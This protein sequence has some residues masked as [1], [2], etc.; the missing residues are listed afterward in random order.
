MNLLA[1]MAKWAATPS[2]DFWR[3]RATKVSSTFQSKWN[4]SDESLRLGRFGRTRDGCSV[5]CPQ[6]TIR[7]CPLRTAD[8]TARK[9]LSRS[10]NSHDLTCV[11]PVFGATNESSAYRILE[12]IIPLGSVALVAW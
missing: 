9:L 7:H 8:S 4:S 6:R 2:G 1:I 3:R 10:I 11:W 12:D 5:R